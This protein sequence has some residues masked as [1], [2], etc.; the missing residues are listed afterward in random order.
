M[1]GATGAVGTI[2]CRL[3]AER[4]FPFESIRFFGSPT[5]SEGRQLEFDGQ[6]YP[7]EPLVQDNVRDIDLA[8]AS[9]PDEVAATCAPWV[10]RQGGLIVD[11]SGFHRMLD[12]VPLVIPEVNP[13]VAEHHQGIIAS[14]NCSTTQMVVCLKPVHEHFGIKR[15][16]VSTYQSASGAGNAARRELIDGTRA[17]IEGS[18]FANQC[19]ESPLPLNLWPKIGGFGEDGSTSEESK[20]VRETRKILGDE[21]LRLVVTCVRVPVVNCHSE[22][23]VVETE[24][25]VTAERVTELF[26]DTPGISVIDERNPPNLPTPLLCDDKDDVFVGRIRRDPSVENGFAF[27]CVSDNLRKGAATNAVQIAEL[28]CQRGWLRSQHARS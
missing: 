7:V 4:K 22:S 9:T 6:A 18:S 1:L 25:P 10:V 15:V 13:Q 23:I 28:V 3:L 16:V 20:M 12:D 5:S 8:I 27:W 14:P 21:S 19:F 26:A 17:A 24:Q 11:E 2:V